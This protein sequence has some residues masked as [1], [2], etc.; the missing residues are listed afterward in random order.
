MIGI[1][2]YS[3][4]DISPSHDPG[5]RLNHSWCGVRTGLL[6]YIWFWYDHKSVF[7]M[8]FN[9]LI[10]YYYF[11]NSTVW[12]VWVNYSACNDLWWKGDGVDIHKQDSELLDL[13]VCPEK[14]KCKMK[15]VRARYHLKATNLYNLMPQ[16]IAWSP[17]WP[18]ISL[19]LLLFCPQSI[20]MCTCVWRPEAD[21]RCLS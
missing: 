19:L 17:H 21:I 8:Y 12:F 5:E 18:Q 13:S 9:K 7:L 4:L 11:I 15:S 2:M 3:L 6:S 10:R 16:R 14:G 1:L 20:C